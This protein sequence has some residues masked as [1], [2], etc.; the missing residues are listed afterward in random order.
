M[1]AEV[2]LRPISAAAAAAILAGRLPRDVT[3]AP[4]HPTEFSQGVAAQVGRGSPLGPYFIHR[5]GDDVVVG[6]IGGGFVADG[7]VEIGYAIVTSCQGRGYATAAVRALMRRAETAAAIAR[8]I[9]HTP[10]DRPA[11]GRVLANAGFACVGETDD[12]HDGVSIRVLRW[13][14]TPEASFHI[15][16][17]TP[18]DAS[19][20]SA[21]ALAAGLDAWQSFLG[22]DRI[23]AANTGR[24]HPAD[25]VA[26]DD[27]GVFAFVAW[28]PDTGEI[29]R[30]HTHPRG[31]GRGAGRELLNR[32]LDALRSAGRT[33][34]WLNTEERNTHARAF[35]ER[36]GWFEEG[37]PRIRDWHGARLVEPRYVKR[38]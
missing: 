24:R 35:Y 28:E 37:P 32:A 7:V 20:V 27:E 16:G 14:W 1:S 4:D 30:L 3:V 22:A 29:T 15:R 8:V 25:L 2:A 34:A 5:A 26:V 11:S 33:E 19:A 9:A 17:A 31:Q 6:E 21:V 38:L 13:Q 12:E 36:Q 23:T 10:L 18:G